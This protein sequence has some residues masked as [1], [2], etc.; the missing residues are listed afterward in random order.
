MCPSSKAEGGT[1]PRTLSSRSKWSARS[2]AWDQ[3]LEAPDTEHALWHIVR[4]D[5]KR[6]VRRTPSY[7]PCPFLLTRNDAPDRPPGWIIFGRQT[8]F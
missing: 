2:H 4:S 6:L 3:M 7:F 5:D 1:A 8:R